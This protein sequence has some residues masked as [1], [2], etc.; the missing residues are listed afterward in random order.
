L[1][2]SKEIRGNGLTENKTKTFIYTK[3]WMPVFFGIGILVVV[4]SSAMASEFKVEW[5]WK[6]ENICYHKSPQI[7]LKNVPAETTKLSISMVDLD[8]RGNYHG[9]GSVDYGGKGTVPKGALGNFNGPCPPDGEHRYEI[10]VIAFD[11][12]GKNLAKGVGMRE[13][14]FNLSK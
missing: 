2:V 12:T 9:G 14:C 6:K 11:E 3:Y 1:T 7:N 4:S 5:E 13:C 10:T 8:R